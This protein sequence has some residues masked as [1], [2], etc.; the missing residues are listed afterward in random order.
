MHTDRRNGRASSR[1]T[2]ASSARATAPMRS[3]PNGRPIRDATG[4]G[5]PRRR[6]ADARDD[7]PARCSWASRAT[8]TS[9]HTMHNAGRTGPPAEWLEPA[10][11]AVA[12]RRSRS[13]DSAR[14]CSSPTP[15]SSAPRQRCRPSSTLVADASSR[16]VSGTDRI[17]PLDESRADVVTLR[18][19]GGTVIE[20][21]VFVLACGPW[22]PRLFPLA[23]G[24][25]VRADA[26]GGAVLRRAAGRS[27]ILDPAAAG[28][29]RLRRRPLRHAR[30][31][32]QGSR[33]ASIGT[34]RRSIPTCRS[35]RRPAGCQHTTRDWLGSTLPGLAGRSTRRRTR[36]PVR[37]HV[38]GRLH[39]RSP[40][41]LAERAGSSAAAPATA[42][43]TAPPSGVMSLHSLPAWSDCRTALRARNE[44]D[45][46]SP[47]RL[48]SQACMPRH[49]PRPKGLGSTRMPSTLAA[50][51]QRCAYALGRL[52]V[53]GLRPDC[54][55][56]KRI[57]SPARRVVRP[58]RTSAAEERRR[59]D[60]DI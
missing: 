36:L 17:E 18:S 38:D 47:D 52:N 5:W 26:T 23:V 31:D 55:I 4:N 2:R 9:A 58:A 60:A 8:S 28:L 41:G 50:G 49:R 22:L 43:S 56:R 44:N 27:P 29:D 3:I 21:D 10:I 48:L 34:A 42:S 46:P 51:C 13:T 12:F 24:G 7:A 11:C 6:S 37:E 14:R 35:R 16:H 59:Q 54:L 39:H 32:A 1:T 15:A 40:S 45:D 19:A 30:F 25:R 33:S 20:A 57:A 53:W